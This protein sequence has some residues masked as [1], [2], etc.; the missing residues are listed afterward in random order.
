VFKLGSDVQRKV[1]EL[2]V[3]HCRTSQHPNNQQGGSTVFLPATVWSVDPAAFW[4]AYFFPVESLL[5][6]CLHLPK[7]PVGGRGLDQ[8][9]GSLHLPEFQ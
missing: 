5:V 2:R 7:L 4:L 6:E 1:G 9:L 3:E 8:W